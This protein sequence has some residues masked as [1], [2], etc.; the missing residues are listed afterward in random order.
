MSGRVPRPRAMALDLG[1]RRVGIAISDPLWL[2]A[3]PLAT[4]ERQSREGDLERLAT[5]ARDLGVAVIVVGWPLLPSGDRG[6][7]ALRAE[8]FAAQLRARVDVPVVLWDESYTTEAAH[9]RR[10]VRGKRGKTRRLAPVD[11]E[12]AAII[13]EEWLAAAAETQESPGGEEADGVGS[14]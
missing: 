14:T 12:A 6:A 8:A 10:Q 1:R 7:S 9:E 13:L 11:A 3:Q 2:T 4:L 5:L